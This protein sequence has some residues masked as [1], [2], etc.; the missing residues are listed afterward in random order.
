MWSYK[1]KVLYSDTNIY[2]LQYI[3]W[4]WVNNETSLSHYTIP[5]NITLTQYYTCQLHKCTMSFIPAQ[6]G[7]WWINTDG[8]QNS[9]RYFVIDHNC[10]SFC[11]K[12]KADFKMYTINWGASWWGALI[13]LSTYKLSGPRALMTERKESPIPTCLTP[14]SRTVVYISQRRRVKSS[15]LMVLWEKTKGPPRWKKNNIS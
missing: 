6:Q 4:N 2:I 10:L 14:S 5:T 13:N 7:S 15:T 8:K 3:L 9:S 1:T 12:A 11:S